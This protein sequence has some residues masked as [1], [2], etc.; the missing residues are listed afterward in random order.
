MYIFK[1][2]EPRGKPSN[3]HWLERQ[4][5]RDITT[6]QVQGFEHPEGPFGFTTSSAMEALDPHADV[7]SD[8]ED[9]HSDS[10]DPH[11]DA[12]SD[13]EEEDDQCED[14][15]FEL[16]QGQISDDDE[17]GETSDG[18]LEDP[19]V[20]TSALDNKDEKT[21]LEVEKLIEGGKL[22]KLKVDQCKLYLR[23]HGLRVTG[24]KSVLLE[25]IQEHLEIKDGS[26]EEKYPKSSF[27]LDCKGDACT[28]DIVMFEQNVYDMYNVAARSSGGPSI[29]T[30]TVA[31]RIIKESY[32]AAKQQH[33]FTIEVLWSKG[34]KPLLPLRSLLIKGRNLYRLKTMRQRWPSEEER[35]RSLQEKHNR[36]S[37]ARQMRELRIQNKDLGRPRQV[38]RRKQ[39]ET[40]P[41]SSEIVHND[42]NKTSSQSVQRCDVMSLPMHELNIGNNIQKQL[43]VQNEGNLN[44]GNSHKI[45][46]SYPTSNYSGYSGKYRAGYAG[47]YPAGYSGKYSYGIPSAAGTGDSNYGLF[48]TSSTGHAKSGFCDMGPRVQDTLTQQSLFPREPCRYFLKGRCTFGDRCKFSHVLNYNYNLSK[49]NYPPRR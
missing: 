46:S 9:V 8:S 36:G 47:Q 28:G 43:P 31:G 12:N 35:M 42:S 29:G 21:Y 27:V 22:E 34:E 5:E 37:L 18:V 11:L 44:H 25:R 19:D 6:K 2:M 38:T 3:S 45:Q 23:K 39:K 48:A 14:P 32:G 17:S 10:E 49:E 40:V 13:S 26:G 33:T 30:R 7:H 16:P 24:R 41:V 4:W 1:D 15:S 20:Q